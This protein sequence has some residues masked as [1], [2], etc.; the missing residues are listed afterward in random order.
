MALEDRFDSMPQ[1]SADLIQRDD[2]GPIV[3]W[4][5][6]RLYVLVRERWTTSDPGTVG[7]SPRPGNVW[8]ILRSG[9]T[10]LDRQRE[11]ARDGF[12]SSN[13]VG[14]PRDEGYGSSR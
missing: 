8:S 6:K 2:T 13:L 3:F 11:S 1:E 12:S 7:S 4:I 10:E 9:R 14:M 5:L